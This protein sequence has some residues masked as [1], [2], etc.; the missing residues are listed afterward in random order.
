MDFRS[1]G[2]KTG[3]S[4]CTCTDHGSMLL[5]TDHIIVHGS[6]HYKNSIIIVVS[7][8]RASINLQFSSCDCVRGRGSSRPNGSTLTHILV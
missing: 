1:V 8:S 5:C 4:L 3:M 6:I 2:V 7:Q